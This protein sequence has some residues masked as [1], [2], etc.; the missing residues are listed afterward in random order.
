MASKHL[1]E[2]FRQALRE[3]GYIEGQTIVLELRWFEG[4]RE[5]AP[6][7]VAELL[8]LKVDVLVAA[9][10]PAALAAKNATQTVP[11]VMATC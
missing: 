4:R 1:V 2:V 7:L 5:R 9:T 3:L 10:G 8:S 11:I 6:Q